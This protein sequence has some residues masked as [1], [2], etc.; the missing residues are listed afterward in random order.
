MWYCGYGYRDPA[1]RSADTVSPNVGYAESADGINWTKPNLG[2]V[3][4]HGN[5]NNNIVRIEP[6]DYTV[7]WP[8]RNIHVL[9]EEDDPDPARRYKMMMYVPHSGGRC[10][11]I[12]LISADGLRWQYARPMKLAE[13]DKNFAHT[14][15]E[16]KGPV[17]RFTI[18][19]TGM[20]NEHLEG[21]TLI[22]FGG[23]YYLN[24][25]SL[26]GHNGKIMGRF[27]ATYWSSDFINWNHEK[28]VSLLRWGYTSNSPVHE[29]REVHEGV[30]LWNRG[31][32]LVGIYGMWQGAKNWSDR[33]L[34]LGLVTSV[35]ATNFREPSHDYVFVQAGNAD[36]W[37]ANGLLQGQG[38]ENVGDKTY[39]WY[40]S[41]DLTASGA[42]PQVNTNDMV[43]SHG[44]VGLLT[45]RRDGFGHVSVLDPKTVGKNDAFGTG[46]GSLMTVAFNVEGG[47]AR[48]FANVETAKDGKVCFEV[49]DR[50]GV[51]LNGFSLG[52]SI[53][54]E[55]SGVKVGVR[56]KS[57]SS[58][59]PGTYR[60]RGQIERKGT[61]SPQ[62]YAF[63]VTSN[64][65]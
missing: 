63:Y 30:A 36:K 61:T 44:D 2:L 31:N 57:G 64:T 3:E 49:L 22:R 8:D 20:P 39:I 45:L 9:Y 21:G 40:G 41:W 52:D 43:L 54:L 11:M 5:R 62:L 42:T 14:L 7:T 13:P 55:Q 53:P 23:I 56:W 28:A 25:Q 19:S 58:I 4:Y 51:P 48:L 1:N 18:E 26:N 27:P 29:S 32:A 35:D 59:P 46:V 37:D 17:P 16:R 33:R 10:T 15:Y 60:V 50:R 65:N 38:F 12:P 34:H 47:S 6:E 24:G